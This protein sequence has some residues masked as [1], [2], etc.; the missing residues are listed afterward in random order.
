[1]MK[2]W[3]PWWEESNLN[4]RLFRISGGAPE[5]PPS[6][7]KKEEQPPKKEEQPPKKEEQPPKKEARTA[8]RLALEEEQAKTR[9]LQKELDQAKEDKRKLEEAKLAEQGEWKTLAEQRGKQLEDQKNVMN[10]RL[11]KS[12][13]RANLLTEVISLG[14]L[15]EDAREIS[16]LIP[17][18]SIRV[19]DE[20]RTSGLKE[21]IEAHKAAH[22]RLYHI[23]QEA[24]KAKGG[25]SDEG[26][27]K[28]PTTEEQKK[29]ILKAGKKRIDITEFLPAKAV[30]PS[31]TGDINNPSGGNP[32]QG[33]EQIVHVRDMSKPQYEDYKRQLVGGGG[34]RIARRAAPTR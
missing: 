10:T 25:S 29:V 7:T 20:G 14:I 11:E 6:D 33:G 27:D 30:Q 2:N 26:G 24:A 8:E 31:P 3:Q 5:D 32:S 17:S 15:P 9:A 18:S 21:A 12:V 13:I 19:D 28:K 4:P 1:M 22:P 16:E 34:R 23:A